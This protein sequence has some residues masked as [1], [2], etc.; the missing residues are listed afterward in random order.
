MSG[1]LEKFPK[2]VNILQLIWNLSKFQNSPTN[3]L[4]RMYGHMRNKSVSSVN[5]L[6]YRLYLFW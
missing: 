1:Y 2:E 4:N 3:T 5:V 6:P